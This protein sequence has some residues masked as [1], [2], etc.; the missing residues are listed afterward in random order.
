MGRLCELFNISIVP[1]LNPDGALNYTRNNLNGIDLNRDFL[2]LS[3]P[4][5]RLLNNLYESVEPDFVL[6][7]DQR[8][9]YSVERTNNTSISLLSPTVDNSK[10]VTSSR[11][12]SMKVICSIYNELNKLIRVM[13]LDLMMIIIPT[14]LVRHFGTGNPDHFV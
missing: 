1:I 14:V 12:K 11:T 10:S 8:S 3:Q 7:C 9:I 4:E 5:S 2:N 6:I 13:Y